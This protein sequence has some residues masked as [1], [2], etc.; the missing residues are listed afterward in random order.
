MNTS[1]YRIALCASCLPK[2]AVHLADRSL[3]L[4]H[5]IEKELILHITPSDIGQ[6]VECT[7]CGNP[8]DHNLYSIWFEDCFAKENRIVT[9]LGKPTGE[10]RRSG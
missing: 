8:L 9:F 5:E 7:C 4:G 6:Y 3:E 1:R 2:F 10:P